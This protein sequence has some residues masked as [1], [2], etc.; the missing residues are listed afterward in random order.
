MCMTHEGTQKIILPLKNINWGTLGSARYYRTTD[1]KV[2]GAV[3]SFLCAVC[4]KCSGEGW[5]GTP[6]YRMGVNKSAYKIGESRVS[7]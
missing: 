2:L 5:F 4:G 7:Q 3:F 1:I 6:L